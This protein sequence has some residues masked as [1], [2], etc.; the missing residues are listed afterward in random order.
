M[1]R[2][3]DGKTYWSTQE[4]AQQIGVSSRTILR[5]VQKG[6]VDITDYNNGK[7]KKPKRITFKCY[8]HPFNGYWFI[9][10]ADVNHLLRVAGN[11]MPK[12]F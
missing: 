7:A 2:V 12:L 6:Y 5:W 3:I 11:L 1:S 10:D 8:R 9:R 4:V